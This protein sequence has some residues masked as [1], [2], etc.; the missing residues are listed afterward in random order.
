MQITLIRRGNDGHSGDL[1]CR[2]YRLLA[3]WPRTNPSHWAWSALGLTC[4]QIA[5]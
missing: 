4:D 3:H 1:G 5:D 2:P